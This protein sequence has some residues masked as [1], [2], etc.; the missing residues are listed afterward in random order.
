[1]LRAAISVTGRPHVIE[2]R[3]DGSCK[4]V[5]LEAERDIGDRL[6]IATDKVDRR[7]EIIL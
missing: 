3:P 5:P 7:E 1:M 4:I 2:A 6:S